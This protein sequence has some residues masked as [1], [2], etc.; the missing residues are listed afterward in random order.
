MM[1]KL[2]SIVEM[3]NARIAR[4]EAALKLNNGLVGTP[5]G[6]SL[7]ENELPRDILSSL[8][9][10]T[11]SYPSSEN[12]SVG[13]PVNHGMNTKPLK[14]QK[15]GANTFGGSPALDALN[16]FGARPS[17]PFSD[18]LPSISEGC[19]DLL[20][21]EN[22]FRVTSMDFSQ[23]FDPATSKYFGDYLM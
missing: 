9:D 18:M 6:R 11:P 3:Q 7:R 13:E 17:S 16:G 22:V 2:L 5:H 12:G 10:G 21:P 19:K 8:H 20:L 23:A 15:T 4:L 14:Q 1:S